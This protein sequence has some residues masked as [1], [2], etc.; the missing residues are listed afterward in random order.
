VP[1]LGDILS[2]LTVGMFGD[3]QECSVLVA[4]TDGSL[5][6]MNVIDVEPLMWWAVGW[7]GWCYPYL[8]SPGLPGGPMNGQPTRR[9]TSSMVD[10]PGV[11]SA[12]HGP[13]TDASMTPSSN[14]V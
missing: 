12:I 7:T 8:A 10:G 6:R 5:V 11:A 13:S 4:T 14:Q 2:S 3:T 9:C 1:A